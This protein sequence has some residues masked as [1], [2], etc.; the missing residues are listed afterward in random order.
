[1]CVL[2]NQIHRVEMNT[3][4]A[5]HVNKKYKMIQSQLLSESVEFESCLKK[6]EEEISKQKVEIE[7]LRIVN[8]EALGLRDITK[9][10]LL[11]H[12]ISALNAAKNRENQLQDFRFLFLFF[13]F[14]LMLFFF[15]S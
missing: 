10:T 6:L 15:E 1:M 5:E 8:K 13:Y 11:K 4:E 3:M 2:E 7:H 14:V 12:E 9:G